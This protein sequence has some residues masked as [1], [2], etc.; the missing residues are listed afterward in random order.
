MIDTYL[1]KM[2][3]R[4]ILAI[5]IKLGL[6]TSVLY[7]GDKTITQMNKK[8][9]KNLVHV[10]KDMEKSALEYIFDGF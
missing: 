7:L 8:K 6:L 1:P 5:L 3:N 2:I 9:N 10:R 4:S